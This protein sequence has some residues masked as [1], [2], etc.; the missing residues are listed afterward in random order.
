MQATD[1]FKS[2]QRPGWVTLCLLPLMLDAIMQ[3]P[4]IT[5]LTQFGDSM[6]CPAVKLFHPLLRQPN[7]FFAFNADY[8]TTK[9]VLAT[10][11]PQNCSNGSSFT[12]RGASPWLTEIS[13]GNVAGGSLDQV[14]RWRKQALQF[15]RTATSTSSALGAPCSPFSSG[16]T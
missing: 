13:S 16:K 14:G 6:A 5:E 7:P 11:V 10:Q 9:H 3:A 4:D 8:C 2:S 15:L 12:R 1:V